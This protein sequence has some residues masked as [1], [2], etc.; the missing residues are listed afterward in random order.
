[1]SR[2]RATEQRLKRIKREHEQ[3][4]LLAKTLGKKY[5]TYWKYVGVN[6]KPVIRN[7]KMPLLKTPVKRSN[8]SSQIPRGV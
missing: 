8:K 3:Q 6:T 5:T 7:G 4:L 1:M 2:V